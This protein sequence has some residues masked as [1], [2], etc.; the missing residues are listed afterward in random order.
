MKTRLGLAEMNVPYR[1][2]EVDIGFALENFE[3][4][5]VKLNPR[6]VVP[7]LQDDSTVVTDSA[8]ILR[9]AAAKWQPAMLGAAARRA[10]VED[11]VKAGDGV[12]LQTITYAFNGVPRGAELL[13]ARLARSHEYQMKYPELG[14]IYAAVNRRILSHKASA[15]AKPDVARALTELDSTLGRLDGRLERSPFI[16][17]ESYSIA[18]VIWTVVLARLHLLK[19]PEV[20][21]E[22]FSHVSAY[23]DRMTKRPSFADAKVQPVWVGGI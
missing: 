23:Y 16:G 10:E 15:A 19:R 11:W 21:P 14:D 4:W 13:E 7:T 12:N 6:A 9:Y 20:S 2:H 8:K 18:D 22:K 3:P 1:S 5:Y 17:G